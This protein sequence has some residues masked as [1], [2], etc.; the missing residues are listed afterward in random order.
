MLTNKDFDHQFWMRGRALGRINEKP[1][2]DNYIHL[3]CSSRQAFKDG[4]EKGQRMYK[5][6]LLEHIVLGDKHDQN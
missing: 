2:F 4:Y 6:T 5:R 1:E 3:R